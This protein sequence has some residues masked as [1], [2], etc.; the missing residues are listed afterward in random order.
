MS[1]LRKAG[2]IRENLWIAL[3][4]IY[5]H[6]LRSSLI[7]LGVAIG[8]AALMGMVSILLGLGQKITQDI[9]SSEGTVIMVMKYDFF[10][11]GEEDSAVR[12]RN[13]T[14]ADAAAIREGCPSLKSV[15]YL[16]EPQGRPPYTLY[17]GNEK[18]RMIQVVGSESSLFDIWNLDLEE[19]RMFTSEEVFHSAKV[20]VLGFSP[21]RD[22]FP[23]KDPIGKRVRIGNDDFTVVGTFIE[24]KTLFGS[25]GENFAMVPYTTFMA[26]LWRE[27]DMQVAYG[28]VR[29][30]VSVVQA[31]DEVIRV[32]RVR[33]K[34]KANEEN[35]FAVTT[36]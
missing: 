25:L 35:D 17:H 15:T 8:V 14:M 23:G 27:R 34:L 32:M 24:R 19:G 36:S 30:G 7:I 5:S 9:S 33:R 22:L 28:A 11:H 20:V 31:T 3:D 26:N 12:R 21:R 13:I 1:R 18:S 16:V 10:V 2:L 6:K 4:V 29:D